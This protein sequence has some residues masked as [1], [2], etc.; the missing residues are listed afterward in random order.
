MR[1]D[2]CRWSC[3]CAANLSIDAAAA[4]AQPKAQPDVLLT[5]GD[6][7]TNAFKCEICDFVMPVGY[8]NAQP[9]DMY[10]STRAYDAVKHNEALNNTE[11]N[12]KKRKNIPKSGKPNKKS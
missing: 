7:N 1:F 3:N 2:W 5:R 8:A 12:E 6:P 9:G 4:D 11:A 10:R